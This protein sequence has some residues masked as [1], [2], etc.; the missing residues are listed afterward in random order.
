MKYFPIVNNTDNIVL[1]MQK[2]ILGLVT[3]F[4]YITKFLE[5]PNSVTFLPLSVSSCAIKEAVFSYLREI[6]GGE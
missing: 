4:A 5:G 2:K 1:P 3:G 6:S